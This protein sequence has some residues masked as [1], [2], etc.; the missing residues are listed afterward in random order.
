MSEKHFPGRKTLQYASGIFFMKSLKLYQTVLS[1]RFFSQTEVKY[2]K[3]STH[4]IILE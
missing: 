2:V 3:N 4:L 1:S